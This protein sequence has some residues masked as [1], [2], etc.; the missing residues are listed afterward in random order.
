MGVFFQVAPKPDV[1]PYA[2]SLA[3]RPAGRAPRNRLLSPPLGLPLMTAECVCGANYRSRP[4]AVKP[5]KTPAPGPCGE[6]ATI[7][8]SPRV[9]L[10][11]HTHPERTHTLCNWTS[12]NRG[13]LPSSPGLFPRFSWSKENASNK[14]ATLMN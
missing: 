11:G 5:S 9:P 6:G 13:H 7:D 4:S 2:S 14:T 10:R 1:P 12:I 8:R 3:G